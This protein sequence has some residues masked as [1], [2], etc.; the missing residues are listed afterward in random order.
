MCRT[1]RS[2]SSTY[3]DRMIAAQMDRTAITTCSVRCSHAH[4]SEHLQLNF[5]AKH[6]IA[7]QLH[8][9]VTWWWCV[10]V[11]RSLRHAHLRRKGA[12]NKG[13]NAAVVRSDKGGGGQAGRCMPPPPAV[14]AR[15][16]NIGSARAKS[17]CA[18]LQRARQR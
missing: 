12:A 15:S 8:R 1:V 14:R 3:A 13:S 4:G 10:C 17:C 2:L 9:S 18:P 11:R 16:L 6:R 5:S 7:N